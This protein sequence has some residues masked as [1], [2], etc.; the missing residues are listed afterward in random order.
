M[1]SGKVEAIH[2]RILN[3]SD[4]RIRELGKDDPDSKAMA[5]LLETHIKGSEAFDIRYLAPGRSGSKVILVNFQ[6]RLPIVI[7]FGRAEDIHREVKNFRT[8]KVEERI[9]SEIRPSLSS[10]TKI[11]DIHASLAYS[12]AGGFDDVETFRSFFWKGAIEDI[13]SILTF[14]MT[15]LFQWHDIRKDTCLPF[16]QW[17][18]EPP[19]V[20]AEIAQKVRTWAGK[21]KAEQGNRL[22]SILYDQQEWRDALVIK[23]C[24]KGIC[25][26]DMN[27]HNILIAKIARGYTP[28]L[29]DFANVAF[30]CSPARDWAKLEREIKMRCLRDK[31]TSPK[32]FRALLADVD[33]R[34]N[35]ENVLRNSDEKVTRAVET[36]KEIREEYT[37]QVYGASDIPDIEYLYYLFC[38]TLAFL[39]NQDIDE[40]PKDVQNAVID[41]AYRTVEMI[42]SQIR[43]D[44]VLIYSSLEDTSSTNDL[45]TKMGN[46]FI[47]QIGIVGHLEDANNVQHAIYLDDD[48]YVHRLSLESAILESADEFIEDVGPTGKWIN[49]MGD[50]GHGKSCLL[51]YLYKRLKADTDA[52]IIPFQAQ[53][54]TENPFENIERTV[55][56]L[57]GNLGQPHATIILIDT[58]DIVVGMD[59]VALAAVLSK[60]RASGYI[61]IT[62]CRRQ[63]ADNLSSFIQCDQLVHLQRYSETEAQE[64][65]KKYINIS[66]PSLNKREKEE[67]FSKVWDLLEQQRQVRDLDFEPLILR[68]IF[69][70]Y[71]P[72]DIPQDINTQRVYRMFWEK[73]VISERVG[74]LRESHKRS[75]VCRFLARQIAFR[76]DAKINSH[77]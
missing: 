72:E 21:E 5:D 70:A 44:N 14:F 13:R 64:A 2:N 32:H 69:E 36:I 9:P 20:L 41:S 28:K 63:E 8:A 48:L 73:K 31:I 58:L 39:N 17:E 54:L 1:K 6:N 46:E 51:W 77:F 68:M 16:D 29:I 27:C 11:V 47:S 66:Y 71:A 15:K 50:A 62:C 60:L 19:E 30:E 42:D 4:S 49:V 25:H 56:A 3:H 10:M 12:W 38:W 52:I 61:L 37:K 33:S 76:I 75:Q 59:D 26:G 23:R 74:E 7:K 53:F 65:I 18:W 22:V 45:L 43:P 55:S 40:A 35:Q 67:Q 24:S 57:I 34:C